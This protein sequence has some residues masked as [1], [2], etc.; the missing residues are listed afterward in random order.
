MINHSYPITI[1]DN[2]FDDPFEVIKLAEQQEFKIDTLGRWPGKRTEDVFKFSP[3]F[4]Y[5][6]Y[7][8]LFSLFYNLEKIKY[9]YYGQMVFQKVGNHFDDGWVH[10][11]KQM[12]L[13]AIIYLN[14]NPSLNS[15][16]SICMPNGTNWST[17]KNLNKKEE[18]YVLEKDDPVARCENNAQFH[19]SVII[20]NKFNRCLAFDACLAHKANFEPLPNNEERL[21]LVCFVENFFSDDFNPINRMR[22]I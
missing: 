19:E 10:V 1:V 6:T 15:G 5:H 7:Q 21:T 11:D 22:M 4:Y 13:T 9:E 8:K 18:S 14:Q 16:T 20:K 2:F 12:L 17:F 3:N